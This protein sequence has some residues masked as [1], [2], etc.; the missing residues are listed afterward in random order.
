MMPGQI[1][2]SKPRV[3]KPSKLV[4]VACLR[5]SHSDFA[6]TRSLQPNAVVHTINASKAEGRQG[7]I[8]VRP[9][10]KVTPMLRIARQVMA[11]T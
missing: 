5:Q 9:A 11:S 4:F 7:L 10:H 2:S 3:C 8:H 1:V 6:S